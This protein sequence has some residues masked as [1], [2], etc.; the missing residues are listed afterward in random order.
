LRY[1]FVGI[2]SIAFILPTLF[3]NDYTNKVTASSPAIVTSNLTN[4][5]VDLNATGLTPNTN[6]VIQVGDLG[7]QTPRYFKSEPLKSNASGS[8]TAS[9]VGLSP[10]GNYRGGVGY[11]GTA[12]LVADVEFTTSLTAPGVK[13][14]NFNPKSGKI[15]DTITITGENFIGV[16]KILFNTTSAVAQTSNSN[17]I[18][19][20]V[21]TG[22]TTGLVT[23]VTQLNGSTSSTTNFEVTS[24]GGSGTQTNTQTNTGTSTNE[25]N[26]VEFRGLVPV[27][28]TGEIDPVT[29]NYKNPCDFNM[30][31]ALIN[32]II[33]FL[34]IT[35]AT[36]LF[37]LITIYV[38]W[39][40]LSDMGST[41]NV[42]KAKKI[43]KNVFIGYIIALAAWLIVKTI[44]VTVG[45]DPQKAFLSV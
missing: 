45:F 26:E 40:Y 36:P 15:G 5:T 10:G 4:I 11:I 41:E 17:S 16:N 22:A 38:G 21:P 19:V 13:I 27:C 23:I 29:G 34:L 9:F 30:V 43:F 33:N 44:L 14:N 24:S 25:Y 37:A 20:N 28:N 3:I 35:L 42:K 31:M 32:K 18:T 2:I 7:G 6:I 8:A 12:N 39:L 1:S